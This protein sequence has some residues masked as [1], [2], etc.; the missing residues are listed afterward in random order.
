MLLI[1]PG[2]KENAHFRL[3]SKPSGQ[4]GPPAGNGQQSQTPKI[5]I[6]QVQGRGSLGFGGTW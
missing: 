5:P 1:P 4:L 2:V 6:L 3:W